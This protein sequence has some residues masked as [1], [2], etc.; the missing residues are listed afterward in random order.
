ME[1]NCNLDTQKE[2]ELA[3]QY[4]YGIDK[5][6]SYK[7]ALKHYLVAAENGNF[8]AQNMVGFCYQFQFGTPTDKKMMIKWYEKADLNGSIKAKY[9]LGLCYY[10]GIGVH[11]NKPTALKYITEAAILD[12]C[13]AQAF[14]AY[15]YDKGI[16]VEESKT[17]AKKWYQKA[18]KNNNRSAYMYLKNKYTMKNYSTLELKE[19][20]KNGDINAVYILGKKA[21]GIFG[22]KPNY[23]QAYKWYT[24]ASEHYHPAAMFDLAMLYKNRLVFDNEGNPIINYGHKMQK[25]IRLSALQGY[26]KAIEWVEE[27]SILESICVSNLKNLLHDLSKLSQEEKDAFFNKKTENVENIYGYDEDINI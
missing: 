20:V 8:E 5:N 13:N 11:K 18:S 15:C 21:E 9:N 26:G 4:F 24:L 14:L 27:Y 7:E 19:M 22:T 17:N 10:Y 23:K 2:F 16:I 6:K 25:L 1:E 3:N 12:D